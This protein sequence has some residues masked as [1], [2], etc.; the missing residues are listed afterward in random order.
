MID[1]QGL[2]S[3]FRKHEELA[4]YVRG[5][6]QE[7]GLK[8][9]STPRWASSVVSAAYVPDGIGSKQIQKIMEDKYDVVIAIGQEHLQ[10][11]I[12]RIGHMGHVSKADLAECMSCLRETLVELGHRLPMAAAAS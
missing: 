2:P 4:A 8:L 6:M 12:I 11:K 1:A 5:A 7:M 9:F 3:I 10:D